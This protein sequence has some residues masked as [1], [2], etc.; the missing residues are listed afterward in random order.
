MPVVT[1]V[2]Q[3]AWLLCCVN[4]CQFSNVKSPAL[5]AL[6]LPPDPPTPTA[7]SPSLADCCIEQ[8]AA[9]TK[10]APTVR[11]TVVSLEALMGST[12]AAGLHGKA[13]SL[14]HGSK[15]TADTAAAAG[16]SAARPAVSWTERSADR[17][18]GGSGDKA[19]T[20]LS[21]FGLGVVAG[22]GPTLAM[23]GSPPHEEQQSAVN[24]TDRAID[25]AAA[26]AA[27]A[28]AASAP[29]SSGRA[30]SAHSGGSSGGAS[31]PVSA[32]PTINAAGAIAQASAAMKRSFLA[33]TSSTA[34]FATPGTA[35][36]SALP[37]SRPPD[38][39]AYGTA[40]GTAFTASS[41]SGLQNLQVQVPKASIE[42]GGWC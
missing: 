25:A 21:V 27:A 28:I 40:S 38:P 12:A 33:N 8:D 9:E 24:A 7:P 19:E 37:I 18:Q 1:L 26:A 16:D 41:M 15:G 22:F 32:A 11:S 3:L 20:V 14:N 17:Q 39:R 42:S 30:G 35:A 31:H 6:H 34:A 36:S 4:N 10:S 5:T 23:G 2:V 13:P 29:A